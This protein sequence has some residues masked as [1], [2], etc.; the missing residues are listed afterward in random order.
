MKIH[1]LYI[2]HRSKQ[3]LQLQSKK[4]LKL[5]KSFQKYL[6]NLHDKCLLALKYQILLGLLSHNKLMPISLL[7]HAPDLLAKNSN[8][9]SAPSYYFEEKYQKTCSKLLTLVELI[10]F[11]QGHSLIILTK[12]I[13]SQ[14]GLVKNSYKMLN[15]LT[16]C[17]ST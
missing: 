15:Y 11:S 4:K 7:A 16:A 2:T 5:T 8:R 14:I 10:L 9:S 13:L 12:N 6:N 17:I 3:N 1:S